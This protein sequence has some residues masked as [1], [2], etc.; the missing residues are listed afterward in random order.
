MM[1]DTIRFSGRV[2]YL[3]QDPACVRAQLEGRP[4]TLAAAGPLRDNLS[5]DE[6]TPVTI[7][8]A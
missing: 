2:L 8:L 3:S 1:E 4:M 6:I 5:T 7:M